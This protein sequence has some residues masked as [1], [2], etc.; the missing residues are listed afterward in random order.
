MLAHSLI[1]SLSSTLFIHASNIFEYDDSTVLAFGTISHSIYYIYRS[2]VCFYSFIEWNKNT[3]FFVPIMCVM[4]DLMLTLW[5]I[6]ICLRTVYNQWYMLFRFIQSDTLVISSCATTEIQW[7]EHCLIDGK[8]KKEEKEK[9]TIPHINTQ[10]VN[11]K[12]EIPQIAKIVVA[13]IPIIITRL[14]W[15]Y[16]TFKEKLVCNSWYETTVP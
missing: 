15:N 9:L 5:I 1:N 12:C 3:N 10:T 14:K 2:V 13:S 7:M 8:M 16:C 6:N 11:S 4:C